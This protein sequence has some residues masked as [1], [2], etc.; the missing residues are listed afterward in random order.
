VPFT[1]SHP[2]AV[3]PLVR[4][5]LVPSALV[6]GSMV[7]DVPYFVPSPVGAGTTHSAI[8]VVT[9]DVVLGLVLYAVWHGL[10]APGAVA[11]APAALRRRLP[12]G[13][14]RVGWWRRTPSRDGELPT[15]LAAGRTA[16][17]VAGAAVVGASLIGGLLGA[18]G[19]LLDDRG[20]DLHLA[21]FRAVTRGGLTGGVVAVLAAVAVLVSGRRSAPPACRHTAADGPG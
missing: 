5:G 17:L 18:L 6:I 1:A 21:A 14:L 7:P 2:A 13:A 8:G 11:L 4:L 16:S 19:P 9:V 10:L 12:E 3:L 15:V 20:A